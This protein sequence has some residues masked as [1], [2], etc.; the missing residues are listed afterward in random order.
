LRL[1][2]LFSDRGREPLGISQQLYHQPALLR[3]KGT[4]YVQHIPFFS[5]QGNRVSIFGKKLRQGDP[6][7]P[8]YL[9][10]GLYRRCLMAAVP[11]AYGGLGKS[12]VF[13]QRVFGPVP[14]C[15]EPDNFVENF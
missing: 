10:Q 14:L 1:K 2:A 13:C 9:I 7:S 4:P 6:K 15:T 12:A 11:A 3:R 5:G 8:A